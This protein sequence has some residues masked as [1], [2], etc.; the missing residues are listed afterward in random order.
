[1]PIGIFE[2][3]NRVP[4]FR[5]VEVLLL[6]LRLKPEPIA[7][8]HRIAHKLSACQAVRGKNQKPPSVLGVEISSE[9]MAL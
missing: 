1:M 6:A 4:I 8:E 3:R 5:C 9:L 2:G 7:I